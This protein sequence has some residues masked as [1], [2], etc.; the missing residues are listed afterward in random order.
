MGATWE[1]TWLH[2]S[3]NVQ[4]REAN[5]VDA[6]IDVNNSVSRLL[7]QEVTVTTVGGMLSR[8]LWD[9]ATRAGGGRCDESGRSKEGVAATTAAAGKQRGQRN[10]SGRGAERGLQR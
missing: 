1:R 9:S 8:W 4:Q 3:G 6:N 5:T 10:E 7:H 2:R